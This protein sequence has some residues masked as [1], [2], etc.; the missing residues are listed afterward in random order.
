MP[1]KFKVTDALGDVNPTAAEVVIYQPRHR[2]LTNS[3]DAAIDGN[4]VSYLVPTTVTM[5]AG[6]YHAFFVLELPMG[7]RTYQ[8]NFTVQDNPR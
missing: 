3:V 7:V 1:L 5:G 8:M 6:E 2:A 4:T